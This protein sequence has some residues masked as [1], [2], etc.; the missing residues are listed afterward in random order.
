[1]NNKKKKNLDEKTCH[2]LFS[3]Y[4]KKR[5]IGDKK[6]AR[7]RF[8]Y[9]RSRLIMNELESNDECNDN[10]NKR[11]AGFARKLFTIILFLFYC[12]LRKK[13]K[14]LGEGYQVPMEIEKKA[15]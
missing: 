15:V 6:Y 14:T 1:M 9:R 7:S 2:I 8:D 4:R 3:D 10:K 11:Y 12:N 13:K 5:Y